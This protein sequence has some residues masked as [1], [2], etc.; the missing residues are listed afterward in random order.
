MRRIDGAAAVTLLALLVAAYAN[1]FQNGFHFDDDHAIVSNP[2]VRSL[3]F[4]PRFF[5]DATTFSVLPLNQTYRP[6]VQT[7]FAFDYRIGRYDPRAY[8]V[9]TFV[10]FV[11]L[12]AAFAALARA[13]TADTT[14][15]LL[16]AAVFALHPAIADTVNYIVQR[17][18]IVAAFGVVAGLLLYVKSGTARR[19]GIYLV[20]VV[21]GMLA[22]QTA[23]A[24][25]FLLAACASV[26]ERRIRTRDVVVAF[27]VT[28]GA[29]VWIVLQTP[30]TNA[31]ASAEPLRYMLTQP[32]VALRYATAFVLPIGLSVDYGWT[33]VDGARDPAL[34]AG[35]AFVIVLTAIIVALARRGSTRTIAFGLA[36]FLLAQLPTALVPLT[37]AGNTWRMFLPFLGLA[38]ASGSAAAQAFA[39]VSRRPRSL[40]FKGCVAVLIGFVLLAE[41]AG[42]RARN[43]VWRSDEA[44]WRDAAEKNPENGRAWMNYGVALMA[45]GDYAGALDACERALP[46]APG[47][48][49]LHV[50]LGVAYGAVG[51]RADAQREFLAAQQLAPDDWRTHLYY[52]QWLQREGRG[53]EA[54]AEAGRARQLNPVAMLNQ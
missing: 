36:W 9:D 54:E 5:H 18:E 24:F 32:F 48:P 30:A 20:P 37:E 31:A 13:L 17:G 38:L 35:F 16:A 53:A 26:Y 15:A 7:T 10:W 34:Y 14:A 43:A 47:Y 41:T 2:Y 6:I 49:L 4:V 1:H 40:V 52:A 3:R 45:R 22:K 39:L 28:L 21:F 51:R 12:V 8:Q 46:L 33:L 11:L 25:P 23:A 44:L 42:T 29:S 19:T 50:N 27:G